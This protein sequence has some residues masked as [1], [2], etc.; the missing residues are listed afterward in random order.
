MAREVIS[1]RIVRIV[2]E[3]DIVRSLY[4]NPVK[5]IPVPKPGQFFMVWVPGY[6]E[7]PMSVSG[8]YNG[9]VRISVAAV[10]KTTERLHRARV[11]E[12]VGLKGPLGNGLIVEKK[13]YLLV[14]GGYGVAPLIYTAQRIVEMGGKATIIIG[15]R[16]SGLLLM[17]NEA[18]NLGRVFLAT[19]DGSKGFKGTA[20]ELAE[21]VLSS[22][23][24]D[25]VV[26]CG[27]EPL[28]AGLALYCIK[29]KI[30]CMVYAEAYMKCGLG[31][32]GS[33][34]LGKSSIILCKD[35]PVIDA[36]LY[37]SAIELRA[38]NRLVKESRP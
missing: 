2:Q 11:G 30:R 34:V 6:E 4:L 32:C 10:G 5:K 33:C 12:Y 24:F 15:A 36:K 31:L 26:V 21:R 8:Y 14:G 17:V 19:D 28:L 27:P 18:K 13:S 16:T 9:I 23:S 1:S 25:V 20:L 22:E 35:G 38:R 3:N 7:V 29:E 37:I